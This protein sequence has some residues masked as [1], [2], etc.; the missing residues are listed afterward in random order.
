[1]A[2]GLGQYWRTRAVSEGA[3][4]LPALLAR[5]GGDDAMR[6]RALFASIGLAAT[7]GDHRAGLEAAAAA[8]PLARRLGA[9]A[10]LVGILAIQ[11]ALEVLAGDLASARTTAAEATAL[12]TRLGD[13]MSFIAA[14]QS[15]AFIAFFDGDFTRMRDLGRAAAA[16][17]EAQGELFTRSTHLTS[18]GMGSLMLGDHAAAEAALRDAL[19]AT[20]AVDDRHGIVMRLQLLATGAAAAGNAERAARLLGAA[21]AL[22][23]QIAA[24]PSPFTSALVATA[25]E[26]AQSGLGQDRYDR[27]VEEGAGLDRDGAVALALGEP[28]AT[29]KRAVAEAPQVPLGR[30]ELEVAQLV[31][32]GLSNK[33]IATRLF[34]SERT[35]ET[36]VYNILNKLGFNS[37]VRIASWMSTRE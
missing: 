12:A 13:D 8:G 4:W 30:R 27:L 26:Q 36:H 37:R 32:E 5:P 33:E 19:R 16:R 9:V 14:A 11:A 35:V 28:L 3:L 20:L 29:P 10:L 15:E 34:L 18:V 31:S 1:M 25:R 7:Q 22:R 17:C 24:P 6:C 21:E 2:A 23:R